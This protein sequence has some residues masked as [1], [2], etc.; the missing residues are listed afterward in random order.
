[1]CRISRDRLVLACRSVDE[2]DVVLDGAK[3]LL[4]VAIYVDRTQVH[5]VAGRFRLS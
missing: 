3:D 4:H 2:V 1:M 5:I